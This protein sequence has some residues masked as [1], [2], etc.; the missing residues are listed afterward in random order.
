MHR[1]VYREASKNNE[2]EFFRDSATTSCLQLSAA[3]RSFKTIP[4]RCRA[5][6]SICAVSGSKYRGELG[7]TGNHRQ[8][9]IFSVRDRSGP[10]SQGGT[11]LSLSVALGD[12]LRLGGNRPEASLPLPSRRSRL[13]PLL[14]DPWTSMN[15]SGDNLLHAHYV[16]VVVETEED[17]TGHRSIPFNDECYEPVARCSRRITAARI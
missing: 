7:G 9:G 2:I 3:W 1:A 11:G 8:R 10:S 12:K 15:F 6:G 14:E 16:T 17:G 13:G 5:S 4:S